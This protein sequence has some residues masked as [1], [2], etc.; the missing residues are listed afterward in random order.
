MQEA[1]YVFFGGNTTSISLISGLDS[2]RG[3]TIKGSSTGYFS[4]SSITEMGDIDGN[5][6][7]DFAFGYYP[8]SNV[9]L[10][11][12]I[13]SNIDISSG[14][15]PNNVYKIS[16]PNS[17]FGYSISGNINIDGS[18][19][20]DL[21]VGAF[22][23]N[24]NAGKAYVILNP[25][26]SQ[27]FA[28]GP[29][30]NNIYTIGGLTSNSY[31]GS[32][33]GV[34]DVNGDGFDEILIGASGANNAYLIYGT[35]SAPTGQPTGRPSGQPM[36]LPSGQ[37][38]EHPSR[39][40]SILPS[41]QPTDRPSVQPSLSPTAQPSCQPTEQLFTDPTA[42]PSDDP[43]EQPIGKPSAQPSSRPSV[44]P[45]LQ[46]SGKPSA[47]PSEQP[48]NQ[49][50]MQPI[51]EPSAQPSEY[52]SRQP[53]AQPS[54]KIQPAQPSEQPS[55]QPSYRPT[56]QPSAQPSGQPSIKPS[57]N[58]TAQLSEQPSEQTSHQPTSQP[59]DNP[60][61]QPTSQPSGQPSIQPSEQPI[62]RPSVQPSVQPSIQPAAEPSLQPSDSPSSQPNDKPTV[63]PS[64]YPSS[65]PSTQSTH[66][67]APTV[68][69]TFI[70]SGTFPNSQPISVIG[71]NNTFK[72]ILPFFQASWASGDGFGDIIIDNPTAGTNYVIFGNSVLS[73]I[74]LT[75]SSYSEVMGFSITNAISYDSSGRSVSSAGDINGDGYQDLIIGVA[76]IS[77]CYVLFGKEFGFNNLNQG[78][79]VTGANK[80]YGT[81]WAVGSAGDINGDGY[82][83]II[84]GAP[85]ANSGAGAAY[86]LFGKGFGFTNVNLKTLDSAQGFSIYGALTSDYIGLSVN[87][88]G[89]IN[90]D[91]FDDIIIGSLKMNS[92]YRGDAYV[93]FGKSSDFSDVYI[94]TMSLDQGFT[95]IGNTVNPSG[96]SVS[97]A[98]D[99]NGDGYADI[100]IGSSSAE[101]AGQISYLIYGKSTA[102]SNINLA[103]LSISQGITIKGGGIVVTNIGDI[104]NDGYDDI[105]I[106]SN[107]GYNEN[108]YVVINPTKFSVSPTIHPTIKP[109]ILPSIAPSFKPSIVPT[110]Q[111]I[112]PSYVP[113]VAP[114]DPTFEPTYIPSNP[115][116]IPT[117]K[118][119]APTIRPSTVPTINPTASPTLL[120]TEEPSILPTLIPT[121]VP[122]IKPSVEPSIKPTV[123]PSVVITNLPTFVP[124]GHPTILPSQTP[125]FYPTHT[126][127]PSINSTE[128]NGYFEV[129]VTDGGNY[130]RTLH[131]INF[132]LNSSSNI[133][134]NGFDGNDMFTIVP[135]VNV[136]YL[137]MNFNQSGD[138][139]DLRLF[140]TIHNITDV[141]ITK[142]SVLI[143]L[144]HHQIVK[145]ANLNPTDIDW[146]NFIFSPI[147]LDKQ[148]KEDDAPS[149]GEIAAIAVL[150]VLSGIALKLIIESGRDC[151]LYY[152]KEKLNKIIPDVENQI[153][154]KP[155]PE[156]KTEIKVEQKIRVIGPDDI[157]LS[158]EDFSL[159]EEKS[160]L[161]NSEQSHSESASI[162]L[163]EHV[164]DG[165]SNALES[166]SLSQSHNSGNPA[167]T[168]SG[169]G[170]DNTEN[171]EDSETSYQSCNKD[172]SS[173]TA[174]DDHSDAEELEDSHQN[175]NDN[176]SGSVQEPDSS[177]SSSNDRIILSVYHIQYDGS[178]T[179]D[180]IP[181]I[182]KI[183]G[184]KAVNEFLSIKNADIKI[185]PVMKDTSSLQTALIENKLFESKDTAIVNIEPMVD[186]GTLPQDILQNYLMTSIL[187][188]RQFIEYL[189]AIKYITKSTFNIS[190]PETLDNKP[191]LFTMHLAIGH[192]GA[193]LLPGESVTNGLIS[194]T[195]GS[196][197]F[198]MRLAAS[199]Y[200]T[201]QRQEVAN[202][203]MESFEITKYCVATILAYTV[204]SVATC[205]I[206]KFILPEYQCSV[207]GLS[208]KTAF[209][210]VECYNV[211]QD[212][213][214]ED[215]DIT[216]QMVGLQSEGY[217]NSLRDE[218]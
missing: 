50:T 193:M 105:M 112:D 192:L 196:S 147:I 103:S 154:N 35:Y 61:D 160:S 116:Y 26:T 199:H 65:Q 75:G 178:F 36:R 76:S 99:V 148:A 204:P 210:G 25:S 174:S 88:A 5:G 81:G 135:Q 10:V 90:G 11:L 51:R 190:L 38:S 153:K 60:T 151:Y 142:G 121:M 80:Y 127:Q 101:G 30:P 66:T 32:V 189:P 213:Y 136:T 17:D 3:Y 49:P 12:N 31:L 202:K 110:N 67:P 21:I 124:T 29:L 128:Q 56:S 123:S 37:P 137:V 16:G 106:G 216:D 208:I 144:A 138:L 108:D 143:N 39:Q 86:V 43:S 206:A 22:A 71:T 176:L 215:I 141:N 92:N 150:V 41:G 170:S 159:S 209:A 57:D 155:E 183:G 77:S 47:K 62:S 129:Q 18:G 85:Y 171:S 89:D 45:T 133:I 117:M 179:L 46:P 95:I 187:G 53:I 6:I 146:N 200:L 157:S 104:N 194:S 28:T 161:E 167:I 122:T 152:T 180:Q 195:A 131:N 4:I 168:V 55:E 52:P 9:Y 197:A 102:F 139:I 73:N 181:E 97:S 96:C 207:V 7:S 64:T 203:D 140:E 19:K 125:T 13:N 94:A 107:Y 201:E 158:S 211:Y 58:P 48:S 205:A 132:I 23:E 74:D 72:I 212:N 115:T 59:I 83:D 44:Q 175:N 69:P 2:S 163:S 172:V 119:T 120:P 173:E 114:T 169:E 118:P 130:S 100:L 34:K 126:I 54:N 40:P 188:V 113:S 145:L 33:A 15:I 1:L 82:D 70:S 24:S 111:P 134:I 165:S 156:S 191:F 87:G 185:N 27:N 91:G 84:I 93:I 198:G 182:Y 109:T 78:F 98:G 164:S 184:I 214:H 149:A 162:K 42:Q 166:R 8:A 186:Q 217:Y 68:M 20:P 14:I 63:H 218:L 79:T 177:S